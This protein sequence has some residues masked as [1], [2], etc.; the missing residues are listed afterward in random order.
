MIGMSIGETKSIDLTYPDDYEEKE[1]EGQTSH[2]IVTVM[3]IKG[4]TALVSE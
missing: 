3:D 1:L 2:A 4:A